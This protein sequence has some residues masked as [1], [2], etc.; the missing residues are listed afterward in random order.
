MS[1]KITIDNTFAMTPQKWYDLMVEAGITR[2]DVE[3]TLENH[4][5]KIVAANI[6]HPIIIPPQKREDFL[7]ILP[8]GFDWPTDEWLEV[9]K[10]FGIERKEE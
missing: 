9:E 10:L 2:E 7:I 3:P 4:T 8:P 5:E 1:D 6:T